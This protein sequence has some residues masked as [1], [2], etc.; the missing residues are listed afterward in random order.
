MRSR[1]AILYEYGRP[2]TVEEFELDPP[3]AGEVLLRL[4]AT[5]LAT[6]G[7]IRQGEH[8]PPPE[9]L[10]ARGSPPCPRS[11]GRG[12]G[13]VLEVGAGCDR[14]APGDH[15]VT[16]FVAVCGHA[17]GAPPGWNTCATRVLGTLAPGMPTDGTFRHHTVDGRNLGHISKIG[18]FAEHTVVSADSLVKID[19]VSRWCPPR[20]W[21]ARFRP[22]TAR[23]RGG[24]KCAEATR[25]W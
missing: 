15:V 20:C 11:S 4:A 13:V 8:G 12:S 5:G 21:R 3:R 14:F 23:R 9:A 1:A 18:A 10:R 7:H 24:P 19:R 6:P 2:W 25:R 16:S 17:G 22:G